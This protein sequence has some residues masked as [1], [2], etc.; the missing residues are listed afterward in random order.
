MEVDGGLRGAPWRSVEVSMEVD[1]AST[2]PHGDLR[3]PPWRLHGGAVELHGD[4]HGVPD[5]V[6]G[7]HLE[8]D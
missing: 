6:G 1:G 8:Y 2:D 7:P 4:L 5:N 3:G